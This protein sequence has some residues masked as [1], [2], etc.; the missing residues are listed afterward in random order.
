M[1]RIR[2][3]NNEVDIEGTAGEL[4]QLKTRVLALALTAEGEVTVPAESGYN[5]APYST[6]LERAVVDVAA[7]PTLVEV[8]RGG[9]LSITASP[10][11]LR[12]LASFISVPEGALPGWHSHYEYYSGNEYIMPN[13]APIVFSLRR[14]TTPSSR[15]RAPSGKR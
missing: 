1:L 9:Q 2:H 7:G 5:P 6:I 3:T 4:Q 8:I 11:N 15:Q 10:D 12:R 14:L 13:S